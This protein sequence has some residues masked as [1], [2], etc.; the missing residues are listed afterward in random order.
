MT[1]EIE[2]L[3]AENQR[4]KSIMYGA[5]C[6]NWDSKKFT[7]EENDL[8][9]RGVGLVVS[10]FKDLLK[11]EQ[12][13][14]AWQIPEPENREYPEM[15]WHELNLEERKVLKSYID[16][17]D[18]STKSISMTEN[19]S[20]WQ[21]IETAP[22]DGT[23]ILSIKKKITTKAGRF[24]QCDYAIIFHAGNCWRKSENRNQFWPT[25]WQ[26]LPEFNND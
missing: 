1:S 18:G 17:A 23:E 7:K 12:L 9:T 24:Y 25:H 10:N 15:A 11:K 20:P 22:K 21:P 3:K 16:N 26:P 6:V 4:L 13:V 8:I 2:K 14:L 19:A 5:C